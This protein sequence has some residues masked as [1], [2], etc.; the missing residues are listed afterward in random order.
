MSFFEELKRRNVFRVGIAYGVASWV[1]LQ[2]VD[3]V[4][5]NVEAPGWVMDVFMMFVVLGFVV[6]LVIAWAYEL[7]PDGIKKEAD[8]EHNESVTHQT[9]KKLDVITLAAV[10]V[11][12]LFMLVD[13][14]VL[15]QPAA[16]ALQQV[17][18]TVQSSSGNATPALEEFA[19]IEN[20]S[21][22]VLP[23][24]NR[25]VNPEDAFFAEGMHDEILTRLSKIASLK[26]ISRT[27]VMSYANTDK[28]MAEI[29]RELGVATLL[30][31]GV[32]R[33]G[34]RVRI[35]VQLIEAAT[36]RHLWAE[37]YD[38][39]LT[40]DN[41]FDIQSEI[42]RSISDALQAVLTGEEQRSL[43][44]KP[45]ENVEA[46]A[47]YLRAKALTLGYGRSPSQINHSIG[48]YQ[49]ALELDPNF[50]SAWAALAIDWTELHW[51]TSGIEGERVKAQEA[52]EKA[53][54]LAPGSAETLIAQGYMHYWGHLDYESALNSFEAAL[55]KKPGSV[56]A[57]RGTA[58]A[59]RR[60]GRLD[61]SISTFRRVIDLDPNDSGMPADLAYTLLHKGEMLEADVLYR[62]SVTQDPDNFWSLWAYSEYF[63]M[64]NDPQGALNMMGK[65]RDGTGE[66]QLAERYKLARIL[67]DEAAM[68]ETLE[69]WEN[70]EEIPGTIKLHHAQSVFMKGE[71]ESYREQLLPLESSFLDAAEKSPDPDEPLAALVMLYAL[72]G[73]EQKLETAINRFKTELK[74]DAI[75]IIEQKAPAYAWA[76]IGN[77]DKA[78]DFAE[79][80][81]SEFGIWEFYYF[82]QDPIFAGLHGEPRY[83]ALALQ[84]DRW[85]ETVQ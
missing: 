35:N 71:I 12:I 77:K 78:L 41:L 32:Q 72:L 47:Y 56:L 6:A 54:K 2:F 26:V 33:A 64:L 57:L 53:Q 4:L 44:E 20:K 3:L 75:R 62:R 36:D 17:S 34:N 60:M 40:A 45:T 46:Y 22:A 30:E 76:I 83:K 24:V 49:A 1:L 39:E 79:Q 52:L 58:Y 81:V 18:S 28:K 63:Q 37:I 82:V 9:A 5:D 23:L 68:Q 19:A 74:P 21:I 27:S 65:I 42:T 55:E 8:V 16:E 51:Q 70:E 11:L 15:Q 69:F 31:G 84:Y 66:F 13:R 73:D 50:S 80:L 14:F 38:R 48:I 29:G 7:T 43:T 10:G 25:S 59:Q 61:Q 67:G 85:L